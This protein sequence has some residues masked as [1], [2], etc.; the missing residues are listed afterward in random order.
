MDGASSFL[1]SKW[2]GDGYVYGTQ[3]EGWTY[4]GGSWI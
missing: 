1:L 2:N 3:G 4:F